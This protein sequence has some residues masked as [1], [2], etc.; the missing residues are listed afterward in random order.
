MAAIT[1]AARSSSW[2]IVHLDQL[3]DE[4]LA[5]SLRRARIEHPGDVVV[6]HHRQ[7]LTALGINEKIR[8]RRHKSHRPSL[9]VLDDI[10]NETSVMSSEAN[11]R[12]GSAK[13]GGREGGR[14]PR[15]A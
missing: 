5:A 10:E 13:Q 3:H 6:T 8:G 11:S 1:E 9:I 7:R 12:N 14:E 4:V 15:L 2:Q